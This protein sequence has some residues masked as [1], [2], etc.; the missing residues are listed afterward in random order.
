VNAHNHVERQLR[1]S[2]AQRALGIRSRL[3]WRVWSRGLSALLLAGITAVAVTVGVLAV[4]SLRHAGRPS[5]QTPPATGHHGS[6]QLGKR[7]KDP[8]PIPRNVQDGAV[9]AAWNTAW[10][11]D[12]LCRPGPGRLVGPGV[13]YAHPSQTMLATIPILRRPAGPVDRLPANLYA[14]G[15]LRPFEFQG[16][17]LYARF[18]R[19]ARVAG[20]TTF[21]LV[22]AADLGRR[23]LSPAS[24]QHCYRLT[25]AALQ[26]ELP[27]V[28]PAKRLATRRYGD[29]EFAVGRYNLET[30]T[31]HEG[32]YLLAVRANA[33]V[34]SDGG[35]SPSA[36]QHTG[37]LG[38]GGEGKPPT[39]FAMDG[40]VPAGVATVT[41]HFPAA[42]FRGRQ[43]PALNA[44]GSVVNNVFVIPIA[45]LFQRGG[46][47][48]TETWRSATGKVIKIVNERAFHP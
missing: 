38:G 8:G 43:L 12:P 28:P 16:G 40:I 44:T 42:R 20:G 17:K 39:S 21:Y 36:I 1:A 6:S 48:A 4:I 45:T 18:I 3:R 35:Q 34:G 2:V 5:Q 29:A 11:K 47:P 30:S 37:M 23:P 24:A 33:L 10:A 46:W 41:L 22:P 7:P 15:H 32:I 14:N 19:R 26:A 31:V 27:R 13:T 9:A 25:V